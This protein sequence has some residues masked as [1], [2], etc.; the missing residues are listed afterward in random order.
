MLERDRLREQMI[1]NAAEINRLRQQIDEAFEHCSDGDASLKEWHTACREL[2]DRYSQLCLPGG[3]DEGFNDRLKSGDSR[4]VE[5]ALCFL[6]VRPY[7][8]RSGYMWKELLRKCRRVPMS[9]E[10]AERFSTLLK[11]HDDW[12]VNREERSKRGSKVRGEHSALFQ[13]FDR[14]FPVFFQDTDL[15]GI[16]TVGGLYQLICRKLSIDPSKS[17]EMCHGKVRKPFSP[18]RKVRS[19]RIELF[20][21]ESHSPGTWNSSDIWATLVA[22]VREAYG[23]SDSFTIDSGTVFRDL[24]RK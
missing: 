13:Q 12:K 4:A 23:L 14:Q 18:G 10:Q 1:E 22:C 16:E 5:V 21:S 24:I 8:V 17:P 2:R 20:R 3:W 6:E 7:F 19:L 11:K 15:D 9:G